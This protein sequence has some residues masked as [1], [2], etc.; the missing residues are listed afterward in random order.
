[1]AKKRGRPRIEKPDASPVAVAEAAEP[2][3]VYHEKYTGRKWWLL[4][5]KIDKE[6]GQ[7]PCHSH[8][9]GGVNWQQGTQ[10]TVDAG[11]WMALDDHRTRVVRGHYT[12]DQIERAVCEV[13]HF[14]VRWRRHVHHTTKGPT[15]GWATEIIS[16]ANRYKVKDDIKKQYVVSGYRYQ[17][18]ASDVPITMYLV[19]FPR[20]MLETG[21]RGFLPRIDEVPSMLDL[22]P[23]LISDRLQTVTEVESAEDEPW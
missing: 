5:I 18:T 15:E 11:G 10:Q 23:S 1:M 17:P 3:G 14:I 9:C 20:S 6:R 16:L 8:I 22:D 19:L 13:K 21:R 7:L 4:G 12:S 2:A